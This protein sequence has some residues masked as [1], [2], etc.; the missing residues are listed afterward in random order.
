MAK[1]KKKTTAA[2][3]GKITASPGMVIVEV[4]KAYTGLSRELKKGDIIEVPE[5]LTRDSAR[6]IKQG[7]IKAYD[8]GDKKPLSR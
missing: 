7:F 2:P 8:K 4:L 6:V 3:K 5:R 1:K